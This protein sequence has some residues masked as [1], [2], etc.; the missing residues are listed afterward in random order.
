VITFSKLEEKGINLG[1]QL[2]R[3][4]SLIGLS[5]KYQCELVI[6]HWK[7]A[8]Y[9]LEVPKQGVIG[10]ELNIKEKDFHYTP[11]FWDQY[12]EAF[13]TKNIDV[14]GFFQSEKY[15]IHCKSKVLQAL[16]FE[17]SFVQQ[18]KEKFSQAFSKPTI[19]I[20]I[21]RGDFA[22]TPGYFLLPLEFYLKALT[23]FFPD[24]EK[25][26][27]IIFSDDLGYCKAHIRNSKNI[28]FATGL[29]DIEQLCLMSLCNHFIISNSTFSWWGAR[30]G[31]K[32][33]TKIIR[34]PY[35]YRGWLSHMNTKD[36]YPERWYV[37]DHVNR[38]CDVRDLLYTK[39]IS[40]LRMLLFDRKKLKH[41]FRRFTIKLLNKQKIFLLQV[42]N[43]FA[44]VK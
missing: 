37:Y 25:Y 26:N 44:A 41:S 1:N 5:E 32:E 6:P 19:A 39:R 33:E 4:A 22:T 13:Q 24:H 30:L 35:Q 17:A 9:F 12:K 29:K 27:I 7:Y 23:E 3:L 43:R 31:E 16:T 40:Q 11:E 21:R 36:Y 8:R 34:S 10:T 15:W 14:W 42:K 18:V 2:H 20:S 28:F 38:A